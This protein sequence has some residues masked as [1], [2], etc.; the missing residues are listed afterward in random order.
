VQSVDYRGDRGRFANERVLYA[1]KTE[2]TLNR[3][4]WRP[5]DVDALERA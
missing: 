1:R 3:V 2:S 4:S 5:A